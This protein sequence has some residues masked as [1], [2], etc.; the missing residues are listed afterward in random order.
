MAV[1]PR[2][3]FVIR[4]GG[5][6]V[7]TAGT[8]RYVDDEYLSNRNNF[9]HPWGKPPGIEADDRGRCCDA[10]FLLHRTMT[11]AIYPALNSRAVGRPSCPALH[12]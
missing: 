11:A 1:E 8:D 7:P 6:V 10:V 12:V 9:G 5:A 2:H 4:G 3:F